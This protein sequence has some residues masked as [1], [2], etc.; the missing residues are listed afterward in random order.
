[1]LVFVLKRKMVKVFVTR[2][3]PPQGMEVLGRSKEL[4]VESWG[5]E[6]VMPRKELLVKIKG[7]HGILVTISDKVD[8]EFLD[9]AGKIFVVDN[10]VPIC[11]IAPFQKGQG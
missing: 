9:A 2:L 3:I 8:Q 1:V 11:S 7:A 4:E 5:T 6:E 10:I